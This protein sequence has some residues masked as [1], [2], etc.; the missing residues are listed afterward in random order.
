MIHS[1]IEQRVRL[2]FSSGRYKDAI[3]YLETHLTEYPQDN[4]AQYCLSFAYLKTGDSNNSRAICEQLLMES[5]DDELVISLSAEIDI[6]EERFETAESKAEILTQMNP[7]DTNHH[8]L[9]GRIKMAQRSYDKALVSLDKSL[10]IDP[11]NLDALNCKILIDGLLGNQ[12]ID[13][14]IEQ[15]LELDPESSY[16]IANQANQML[17]KGEVQGALDRVHYALSQDPSNQ[18]AQSVMQEALKSKFWPY[19]MFNKYNEYMARLSSGGIWKVILGLYIGNQVIIRIAESNES[20]GLILFPI[21]YAIVAL[22]VLSWL[23]NPLMNLYLM[24]NKY[25]RVL[26]NEDNKMMAK[27]TGVALIVAVLSLIG[28]LTIGSDIFIWLAIMSALMM[29]PMATFLSPKSDK[30]RKSL[31]IYVLAL[32]FF[33][34]T[35]LVTSNMTFY[36]LF[37]VGIFAYQW[38]VNSLIIK[39][40]SRVF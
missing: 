22:F 10:E 27:C 3:E 7:F 39:E 26:L 38:F 16:T 20:L 33:M 9:M 14:T 40:N 25:G 15:A 37:L 36:Y 18:L 21:S 29:I 34:L 35:V 30:S 28:Y 13:S 24:T 4:Y 23:I 1:P 19:R 31:K 12:S 8:L 6:A 32:L 11:E 17:R 2:L 5:P